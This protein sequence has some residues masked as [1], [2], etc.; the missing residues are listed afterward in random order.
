MNDHAVVQNLGST[1]SRNFKMKIAFSRNFATLCYC[2]SAR[3]N[4]SSGKTL[5]TC[6]TAR[7]LLPDLGIVIQGEFIPDGEI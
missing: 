1:F 4:A 5:F 3:R 6:L 7:K 2:I